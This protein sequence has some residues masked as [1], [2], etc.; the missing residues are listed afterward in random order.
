MARQFTGLRIRTLRAERG[1]TQA[2]LAKS[3]GI[4]ASY[5]NLIEGNKRPVAGRLLDRLAEGLGVERET[6]SGD[7]ERHMAEYLNEIIADPATELGNPPPVDTDAFIGRH[8]DWAEAFIKLYQHFDRQRQ[9]V[10]ALADRLNRDPFLG[11]SVHRILTHAT[12]IRSASEIL[13]SAGT[14]RGDDRER[15]Q[16][17]IVADSRKLSAAAS[18]LAAFFD[19]ADMRVEAST[20]TEQVDAFV[21]DAGNY[22]DVLERKAEEFAAT[23]PPQT[24]IVECCENML[25]ERLP[26]LDTYR[27]QMNA[28]SWRFLVARQAAA[29]F[30][31][32]AVRTTVETH[33]ALTTAA[34]REVA[35]EALNSYTAAALLM[36]YDAFLTAAQRC[37]YD[38]DILSRTFRASYEQV[39]HRLA[40]LHRPG[41]EGLRLAFMRSDPSG[42]IDKRLPLAKLPLPRYGSACPLWVVYGAFQAP[43]VTVRGYGALPSGDSF[44]FFA[45]AI[46]KSSAVAGRPRRLVSVMLAAHA[47]DVRKIALAD[48]LDRSSNEQPVGTVCRLCTRDACDFRQEAAL[49]A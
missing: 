47:E 35:T 4:S 25:G 20:P 39:A 19:N 12:A 22:F 42:Y 27:M 18:D 11:E 36:P 8:S 28:S 26:H 48:D 41:A 30:C 13:K 31:A 10:V 9:T 5:L 37:R 6:L 21:Y 29:S 2:R 45:R 32:D 49:I 34:A 14:L 43:G 46:D 40:T 38:I 24:D 1:L 16:S 15:F 23:F 17:I 3:A 7:A 44:F 33:R